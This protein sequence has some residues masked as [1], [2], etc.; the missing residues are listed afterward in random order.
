MTS[1]PH[2]SDM[3]NQT[4]V[5]FGRICKSSVLIGHPTNLESQGLCLDT[6]AHMNFTENHRL[7]SKELKGHIS[8]QGNQSGR[9]L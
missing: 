4:C 9:I 8:K 2:K 3:E 7:L 6:Y 5:N 1:P